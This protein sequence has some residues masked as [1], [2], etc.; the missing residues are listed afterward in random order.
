MTAWWLIDDYIYV[1]ISLDLD[2]C[3]FYPFFQVKRG[4][5]KNITPYILFASEIRKLVT[6]E[7]KGASFGEISK[8]VGDKVIFWIS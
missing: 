6:D 7:N 1:K 5:N 8:L 2:V 3:F 4:G